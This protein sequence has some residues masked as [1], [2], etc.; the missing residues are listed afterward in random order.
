M[1]APEI[2]IPDWPAPDNIVAGTTSRLGRVSAAPYDS[3]NLSSRCG[4]NFDAV[5]N[6]RMLLNRWCT[7]SAENT[8]GA[9][10]AL[11]WQWL[12]QTHGTHVIDLDSEVQPGN[13]KT[14]GS[15]DTL[16]S[17]DAAFSRTALNVCAVTTADCLPVLLCDKQGTAV[18]A[19]HAGW[20]GLSRGIVDNAVRALCDSSSGNSAADNKTDHTINASEIL[21]WLGP[22]IG[23]ACFEVGAEVRQQFIDYFSD[24]KTR[25]SY[26]QDCLTAFAETGSRPDHYFADLYQLATL[27]LRRQGVEHIY[28]GGFCT[29]TEKERFFSYRRDGT[30]GRM[31]SFIYRTDR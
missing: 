6:N 3:F 21:A 23:P 7:E 25:N 15:I 19:I 8:T 22:A 14:P 17:A 18:A 26:R 5:Q 28:G 16:A 27:A 13:E 4:D 2:I 9:A 24:G 29:M 30:T 20:R 1:S 10:S 11:R 12:D 31:A